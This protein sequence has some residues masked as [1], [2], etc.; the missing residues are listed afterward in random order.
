MFFHINSNSFSFYI[1]LNIFV[2]KIIFFILHDL[3]LY[4]CQYCIYYKDG[5]NFFSFFKLVS[6]L[7]QIFIHHVLFIIFVLYLLY[8]YLL[9]TFIIF[10]FFFY[11]IF[12]F[13]F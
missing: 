3:L 2:I 7:I 1:T 8:Y 4:F 12:N 11:C 6:S 13:H 5:I 9:V 10:L